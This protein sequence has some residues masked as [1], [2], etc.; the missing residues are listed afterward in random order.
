[1]PPLVPAML[2]KLPLTELAVYTA[3]LSW[4]V[5]A[6]QL[7]QRAAHLAFPN[8]NSLPCLLVGMLA[9]ALKP[10]MSQSHDEVRGHQCKIGV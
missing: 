5:W 6:G 8:K 9:C 4:R 10:Y 2:M 1:M 7:T 3:R